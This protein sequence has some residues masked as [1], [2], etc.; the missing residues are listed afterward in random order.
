MKHLHWTQYLVSFS[1][2]AACNFAD[3]VTGVGDA[4][5]MER[6]AQWLTLPLEQHRNSISSFHHSFSPIRNSDSES[7]NIF[8]QSNNQSQFYPAWLQRATRT[9]SEFSGDCLQDNNE[10]SIEHLPTQ[11]WCTPCYADKSAHY[12]TTNGTSGCFSIPQICFRFS[13]W[14]LTQCARNLASSQS[15]LPAPSHIQTP[16]SSPDPHKPVSSSSALASFF[17]HIFQVIKLVFQEQESP[18][19]LVVNSHLLANLDE[20]FRPDLSNHET[21]LAKSNLSLF[22]YRRFASKVQDNAFLSKVSFCNSTTVNLV[23][24]ESFMPLYALVLGVEKMAFNLDNGSSAFGNSTDPYPFNDTMS[25]D[26]DQLKFLTLSFWLWST[27]AFLMGIMSLLTT[28]G[29]MLVIISFI[30]DSKLRTVSNFYILNLAIAD[31][32]IGKCFFQ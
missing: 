30:Y 16:F 18:S 14:S 3:V 23:T 13:H 28:C 25:T 11:R 24:S 4:L 29:N 2:S 20:Q 7:N 15:A 22:N 10:F 32:L 27:V 17:S 12:V 19:G 9:T 6:Q 5:S 8:S 26:G 21:T 31:F 1:N